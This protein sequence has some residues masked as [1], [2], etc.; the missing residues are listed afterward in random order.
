MCKISTTQHNH[1]QSTCH[2]LAT[3]TNLFPGPQASFSSTHHPHNPSQTH[4]TTSFASLTR[5]A[6]AQNGI[7]QISSLIIGSL[8]QDK[9][10][11]CGIVTL[12]WVFC[13][14]I[15]WLTDIV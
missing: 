4:S 8:S 14:N 11:V 3:A 1:L 7:I 9:R 5:R 10:V 6:K 15:H 2:Q 12:L 13:L